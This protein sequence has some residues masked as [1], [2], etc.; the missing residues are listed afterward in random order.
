MMIQ[1][2]MYIR[3]ESTGIFLIFSEF[4]KEINSLGIFWI[5]LIVRFSSLRHLP[6]LKFHCAIGCWDRT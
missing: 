2:Q 6:P 5:F 1:I 3:L 4:D